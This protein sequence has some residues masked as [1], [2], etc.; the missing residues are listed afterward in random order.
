[1]LPRSH[2]PFRKYR[3]RVYCRFSNRVTA[4]SA[5]DCCFAS[6]MGHRFSVVQHVSTR[7]Y[8]TKMCIAHVFYLLRWMTFHVF[9]IHIRLLFNLSLFMFAPSSSFRMSYA[10]AISIPLVTYNR[11]NSLLFHRLQIAF[12]I[13]AYSLS[14]HV[15]V[16]L[17]LSEPHSYHLRRGSDCSAS[18][19]CSQG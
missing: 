17:Q 8:R 12:L 10:Q 16:Q 3:M 13:Q 19:L 18:Q 5:N 15:Y 11:G 6:S 7:S 1:M 14:D 2:Y 4:A 9:I